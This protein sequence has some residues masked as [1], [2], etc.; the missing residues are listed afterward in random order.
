MDRTCVMKEF[1][2]I[3]TQMLPG[4]LQAHGA[5]V[6]AEAWTAF[7]TYFHARMRLR[8]DPQQTVRAQLSIYGE[9]VREADRAINRAKRARG[10]A[11]AIARAAADDARA[12]RDAQKAMLLAAMEEAQPAARAKLLNELKKA[13]GLLPVDSRDSLVRLADVLLVLNEA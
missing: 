6:A 9:S 4:L 2:M 7:E 8:E 10:D 11:V 5:H 3:A 12:A 13:G 1:K